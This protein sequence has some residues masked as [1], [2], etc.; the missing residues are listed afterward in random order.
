LISPSLFQTRSASAQVV[1]SVQV[2]DAHFD[3]FLARPASA[4]DDATAFQ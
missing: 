1:A 2:I 3:L 4:T